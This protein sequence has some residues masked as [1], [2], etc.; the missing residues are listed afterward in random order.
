MEKRRRVYP[1]GRSNTGRV[2][3]GILLA[4]AFAVVLSGLLERGGETFLL[5]QE[6][7]P[8]AVPLDETFDETMTEMV[9]DLPETTWYALQTGAFEGEEA[10][11]QSAQAFQKRGAAGYLWKDGRFRVLAAAYPSEED[12]RNVRE[13]LQEQH[14]IDSYLYRISFPSI[15]LRLKGMQ[16][17]VEILQASFSHVHA[18]AVQLQEFS[19]DMDRQQ[20]TAMEMLESLQALQTQLQ[21]VALRLRQRFTAPVP[22]TVKTLL[23]CFDGYSAFVKTLS[24]EESGASLGMKLKYHTFETLWNIQSVYQTLSHT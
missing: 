14:N 4:A 8:S 18:L 22:E 6:P 15:R 13:Q 17:Q 11:R 5:E 20:I 2:L 10:A 19:V 9:L 3:C 23:D 1:A 21:I 16:G 12:A 24:S 7:A